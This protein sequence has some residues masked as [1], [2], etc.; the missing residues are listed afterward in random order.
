MQVIKT[1]GA[2][3]EKEHSQHLREV[4]KMEEQTNAF[5]NGTTDGT[6]F[7][8]N[9]VVGAS[10]EVD[11][12]ALVKGSGGGASSSTPAASA[13]LDPWGD[14]GWG[15]S[16]S[17]PDLESSFPG[18]NLSSA[19]AP[20]SP[21]SVSRATGG[22]LKAR[23]IPSSSFNASVFDAAPQ[24]QRLPSYSSPPSQPARLP[25]FG[26]TSPSQPSFGAPV[27]PQRLGSFGAATAPAQPASSGPNY[28]LS[29]QPQAPKPTSPTYASF[30]AP[31]QLTRSPPRQ[32]TQPSFAAP[33]F[34]ALPPPIA[35]QPSYGQPL[36][37]AATAPA[38]AR[39][40]PGW[41]SGLMQPTAAPKPAW[42]A[43]QAS[44]SDWGDFDPLK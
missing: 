31:L 38:A 20:A 22:K 16:T 39:P 28:N 1:L 35:A 3:V 7:D 14:D 37:P 43:G 34:S 40:P 32:A 6:P 21:P 18:L 13:S 5:S 44:K 10:G 9:S 8:F 25:S 33:S 27:Q 41:T 15:D 42:G 26:A 19:P 29:L 23:A 11:F 2:R 4:R 36:Q 17:T 12:E 24:P 30:G